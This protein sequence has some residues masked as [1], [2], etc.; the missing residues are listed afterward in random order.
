MSSDFEKLLGTL[1]EKAAAAAASHTTRT[2]K[3]KVESQKHQQPPSKA[4][5]SQTLKRRQET[6]Q[7]FRKPRDI[8]DLK[9]RVS[10]FCIGAQKAGTTWLHE[11][12]RRHHD[13]SLPQQKESH[14]FDWHRNRG[15]GWYSNQ[16]P[17]SGDR[18]C[19]HGEIT[20]CYAVLDSERI[21]EIHYL[22]PDV[23]IIFLARDLVDRAWSAMLMELRNAVLGIE[24]G[25]F[26]NKHDTFKMD[27]RAK[28]KYLQEADPERYN[29]DYFMERLMHATHRDRS[30][31]ASGLRKWLEFFPKE[32]VLILDYEDVSR[33]PRGLLREIL[34][35]I[36]VGA[37]KA[38]EFVESLGEDEINQRFN[39]APDEK[40]R[41]RKIRPG[42]RKKMEQFLKPLA[43]DFNKM[44]LECGYSSFKLNEYDA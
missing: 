35:F 23:K 43:E 42:L 8:C 32:Q 24:A 3:R 26:E 20:P 29:D 33:R 1:Q 13:L 39:V 19:L 10:F 36:G 44:L 16:W 40:L 15:L 25:S 21:S 5:N 31:Y 38:G 12:L 41:R 30:D 37:E 28:Q 14:F 11:M 2:K 27:T 6:K 4:P 18:R 17:S 22:F 9:V 34:S 7:R